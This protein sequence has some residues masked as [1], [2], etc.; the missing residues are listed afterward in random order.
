MTIFQ[1]LDPKHVHV[2]RQR[3]HSVIALPGD[4]LLTKGGPRKGLFVIRSGRVA[5]SGDEQAFRERLSAFRQEQRAAEQPAAGEGAS[6]MASATT[7]AS[8]RRRVVG[9][10][11]GGAA[12]SARNLWA[13][14]RAAAATGIGAGEGA[15]AAAD[16]ADCPPP[17]S[18]AASAEERG[19]TTP[20]VE[21]RATLKQLNA[22]SQMAGGSQRFDLERKTFFLSKNDFFGERSLLT[23][24]TPTASCW[25]VSYCELLLLPAAPFSDLAEE[26][27]EIARTM[28]LCSGI[29][30]AQKQKAAAVAPSG[31]LALRLSL[32][33]SSNDRHSLRGTREG[34]PALAVS[35]SITKASRV[36]TRMR[37]TSKDR[38]EKPGEEGETDDAQDSPAAAPAGRGEGLP[39]RQAI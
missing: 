12:G 24:E 27:P 21:R 11:S 13:R 39:T 8:R 5:V 22:L 18:A 34:N 29:R 2:I 14:C 33:G 26:Y 32:S 23:E 37:R 30:E 3:M 20:A 10:G 17:P 28:L 31:M 4:L 15:A 16:A 35:R 38:E 6:A 25:A 36:F 7:G 9:G 1:H 19:A